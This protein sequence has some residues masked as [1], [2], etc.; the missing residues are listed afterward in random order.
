M[1]RQKWGLLLD[2]KL[3]TRPNSWFLRVGVF[4]LILFSRGPTPPPSKAELLYK[5]PLRSHYFPFNIPLRLFY[6]IIAIIGYVEDVAGFS[7]KS[8]QAH[9]IRN[10]LRSLVQ[11]FVKA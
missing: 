8:H 2:Y 10:R 5:F 4:D 11:R 9:A 7:F 6:H 3:G 1:F